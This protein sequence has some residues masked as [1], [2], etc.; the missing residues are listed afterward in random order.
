MDAQGCGGLFGAAD[1]LDGQ[2]IGGFDVICLFFPFIISF[3]IRIFVDGIFI[4]PFSVDLR[5]S[6]CCSHLQFLCV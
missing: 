1:L 3:F 6:L 5:H 4:F 2:M